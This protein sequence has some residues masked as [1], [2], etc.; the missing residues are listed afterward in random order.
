[1]RISSRRLVSL[2]EGRRQDRGV[3]LAL[4]MAGLICGC[5]ASARAAAG[6]GDPQA[7]KEEE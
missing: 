1:M 3:A 5:S 2:G 4:I 6:A 7:D